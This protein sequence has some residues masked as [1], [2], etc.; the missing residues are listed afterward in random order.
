VR[1]GRLVGVVAMSLIASS[2]A[3]SPRISAQTIE[4]MTLREKVGQLVM[5]SVS[6]P[7]LSD[8]ERD[9]IR[10]NHLGS[11]ILFERNYRDK[12]QLQRL[13][14]QIQSAAR[15]GTD[16]EIGALI[17]VDQEGGIVKRFD[18][19]PPWYS[20]PEMGR[21]GRSFTAEQGRKTGRALRSAGVNVDLAPVADLDIPPEHVMRDR[22]FGSRPKRVGSLVAAFGNGLQEHRVAAVAK[23]FP[24]L[25]G[26]T[27][28]TDYGPSYVS[29]SKRQL[30]RVDRV[31]F[32][33]AVGARFGMV[34][35]SH[36]MYL[37]DGG[38]IPASMSS[39]LVKDR[40]RNDLGYEGVAVSDALEAVGWRF[41]GNIAKA[42]KATIAAGVDLA[43]ITGGVDA[44]ER[45]ADSIRR[46]V[47]NDKISVRRIDEAV[48]RVL[49]LKAWTGVGPR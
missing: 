25:G 41:D 12:D 13:T 19:M 21:R 20:A 34:M 30:R 3:S 44:A 46:A 16:P 39:H 7:G 10:R 18:D 48:A 24:G 1:G 9:S 29:R 14:A 15:S 27:R 4:R 23:H 28:N 35:V 32:E 43:L 42:C 17:A 6:G 38:R 8:H 33:R 2:L 47:V 22:A 40:L 36:A 45:C 5:F 37:K 11:V 26:A 49:A 31:P